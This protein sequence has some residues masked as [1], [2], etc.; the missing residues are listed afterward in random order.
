MREI[1]K[2]DDRFL[3]LFD[4]MNDFFKS[5][6]DDFKEINYEMPAVDVKEQ[7]HSYVLEADLPGLTEKDIHVD[8]DNN[9]LTLSSK[10]EESKEEKD[11][12]YLMRERRS[13]SFSRSF[14]LPSDV[15]AEHIKADFHDGMLKIE[16]PRTES[17]ATKEIPINA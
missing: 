1:Q 3:N 13:R 6:F 12:G 10:K 17:K 16:I 11:E 8:V 7:D 2:Y 4:R 14:V 15:D 9:V 5:F